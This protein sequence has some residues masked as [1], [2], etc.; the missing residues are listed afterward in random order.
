MFR[1]AIDGN[2]FTVLFIQII[3]FYC[4][5]PSDHCVRVLHR[6]LISSQSFRWHKAECPWGSSTTVSL[7][8][9]FPSSCPFLPLSFILTKVIPFL[10]K[11]LRW[12]G[13]HKHLAAVVRLSPCLAIRLHS[14]ANRSKCGEHSVAFKMLRCH[15]FQWSKSTW[16][17]WS[18]CCVCIH[19]NRAR[20]CWLEWITLPWS[21]YYSYCL[22]YNAFYVG[23]RAKPQI[24]YVFVI[25]CELFVV[26]KL[27]DGSFADWSC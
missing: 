1:Y 15:L 24:K 6:K 10:V 4:T 23:R 3:C 21:S 13:L 26:W 19:T 17:W 7:S 25:E 22:T 14:I 8:R 5:F 12:Q 27:P 16:C 11:V 18:V 2:I 9:H 20:T